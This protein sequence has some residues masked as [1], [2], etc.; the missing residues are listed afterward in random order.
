[1][2][3]ISIVENDIAISLYV[4]DNK[5]HYINHNNSIIDINK[6]INLLIMDNPTEFYN[7]NGYSNIVFNNYDNNIES[8]SKI[9]R[10]KKVFVAT[11][12]SALIL[13]NTCAINNCDII[14][15]S[16]TASIS[17]EYTYDYLVDR[18][19]YQFICHQKNKKRNYYTRDV[20]DPSVS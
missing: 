19:L 12:L 11:T 2:D 1:M 3:V 14:N 4:K 18:I 16:R 9:F 20:F 10:F 17:N 13:L 7:N 6:Y 5:I 15:E 8:K